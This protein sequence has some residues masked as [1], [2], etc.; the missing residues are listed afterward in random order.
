MA[1]SGCLRAASLAACGLS[2]L[3]GCAAPDYLLL[4]K[5]STEHLETRLGTIERQIE[6]L[7]KAQ[8]RTAELAH[9]A[10]LAR[11]AGA[12]EAQLER[13]WQVPLH[14]LAACSSQERSEECPEASSPSDSRLREGQQV[15]AE[16]MLVFGAVEQVQLDP[17]GL[18][19]EARMDTGAA[20]SSLDA[21]QVEEF[22]R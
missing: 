11:I 12:M 1:L 14:G 10:Q 6:V 20:T 17:P 8:E 5:A 21:R 9:E 4:E 3:S 18:L 7:A 2:L 13:R 16:G 22:E 19:F 15:S